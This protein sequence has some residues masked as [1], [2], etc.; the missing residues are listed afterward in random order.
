MRNAVVRLSKRPPP[1]KRPQDRRFHRMEPFTDRVKILISSGAGGDGASIMAHEHS[2]ELAGPGGGNG[3]KGGNVFLRTSR[4]LSD[5]AH[6]KQLGQQVSAGIGRPGYSRISHG[7][8]GDA[9]WIDLP[10]G[11]QIVDV[12]TNELIYDL[13]EDRVEVLLLEGGQGGKG[14]A[15][16]AN[17]WHHS[18]LEST[19]GLPG[20]TM[21]AQFELKSIAD[22][23]LVG[24]PNAGKSSLLGAISSSR[25]KVAPY[26]F[27][28]LHPT[29]GIINDLYGNSCR[30]ADLPGLIEGAYENRGLGHQFLRHVER[31]KVLSYVVDMTDSYSTTGGDSPMPWD[32]VELLQ[33]E[34]EFY[35]PGLSERAVM[36]IANKMDVAKDSCGVSTASKLEELQRRVSLPVFPVSATR[37]LAFGVYDDAA[38]L[39]APIQFLCETVASRKQEASALVSAQREGEKRALESYFESKHLGTFRNADEDH[40][41]ASRRRRLEK[42]GEMERSRSNSS[43]SLVDQQLGDNAFG[44]SGFGEEFSAYDRLPDEGQFHRSR[45]KTL[46]GRYW[47]LSRDEQEKLPTEHWQ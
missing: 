22:C 23:G 37:G 21:L 38:G 25:P 46:R 45:D 47:S 40:R 31:T 39:Q 27:T 11:T 28:T 36:V 3:G 30:I 19:R 17:K 34:L 20:N 5:L 2:N 7:R 6:V 44:A 12:D 15:A 33:Q 41:I 32:V 35:M 29:V 43:S 4:H 14:N 26:A 9:L 1:L 13:D 42:E 10:L 24:L 16:F 8:S 18:P